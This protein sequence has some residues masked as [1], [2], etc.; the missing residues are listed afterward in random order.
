MGV[1]TIFNLLGPLT[2]PAGA[3]H[4]LIGVGIPSIA[5]QLAEVLQV[6]GSQHA[7][8]VHAEEGMDEVGIRGTTSVTDFNAARG[9]IETYDV[10]PE[11]FGLVRADPAA[12]VGGDAQVN[13]E[14]TL[15]VLN[16]EAGPRRTV[17]VL[18]A[19][20]GIYAADAAESLAEGVRIAS[21]M[22]DSGEALAKVQDLVRF[23]QELTA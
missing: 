22:I 19:G 21:E 16:G 11:D 1:R 18:N 10:T 5:H 6:L 9:T 15:S 13:K 12:L 3:R 7:V 2:N 17:T 8:L 14:I 23:T 4:Q 20:A